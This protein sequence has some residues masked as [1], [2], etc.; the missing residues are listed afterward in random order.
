MLRGLKVYSRIVYWFANKE[1][2]PN[3]YD[4]FSTYRLHLISLLG[5]LY[6]RIR[7]VF[8]HTF[9]PIRLSLK[10]DDPAGWATRSEQI[11]RTC[12]ITR[13]APAV[14]TSTSG[15]RTSNTTHAPRTYT[16]NICRAW[17]ENRP[18]RKSP[19]P[20]EHRCNTCAG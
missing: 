7:P 14:R 6:L 16:P 9:V 4:A 10:Q 8:H 13:A 11:E 19:C 2:T 18:C 15:E 20:Y 12:L 17:N 5:T 3:L 1:V